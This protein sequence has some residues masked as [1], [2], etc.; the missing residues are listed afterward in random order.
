MSDTIEGIVEHIIFNNPDNGYTVLELS[1]AD[2]D[3]IVAVGSFPYVGVGE[4]ILVSGNMVDNPRYGEQFKADSFE[5]TV[6]SEPLLMERYLGSGAIKGVGKTLARRIVKAFGAETRHIIF[7]EPERLSEIKGIS[8]EKAR[9]IGREAAQK[10]DYQ[11]AMIFLT[12]YGIN[13]S[14]AFKLFNHYHNSIYDVLKT[15]PYRI[16][17]E[18]RG[19]GFLTADEIAMRSGLG[20]DS[21][22][23][24]RSGILY[25]LNQDI[26]NGNT[27][28]L[29][30]RLYENTAHMLGIE[31]REEDFDVLIQN[32]AFDR[33]IRVFSDKVFLRSIYQ[34]ENESASLL[35]DLNRIDPSSKKDYSEEIRS[36]LEEEGKSPDTMQIRAI[37]AAFNNGVS[38]L[39][40]GPGTG[41]T[42]TIEGM[43][44]FFSDKGKKVALTAPTGRAAKRMEETSGHDAFTIHRLLE[45]RGGGEDEE[46]SF[47][48]NRD[49]PLE[50]DVII[51][52]EMSMVDIRLFHSLLMAVPQGSRL[53]LAGDADQLPSVGPGN[54][55]KDIINSGAFSVVKLEKIFRQAEESN[56]VINAHKIISGVHMEIDNKSPDFCFLE[57]DNA[58]SAMSAVWQLVSSILPRHFG[59]SSSD[60]QVMSPTKKGYLGARAI[61][62]NLQLALNPHEAGKSE[63]HGKDGRILRTGDKVMQIKNNYDAEWLVRGLHG[64]AIESGKGVYNGDM[65]SIK[66]ISEETQE[67]V[68]EYDEKREVTYGFSELD[69]LELAYCITIHKSQ[70]SEYEA[71]VIPLLAVPRIMINRNLLYTAVTRARKSVVIVGER[72]I[73]DEMIDQSDTSERLTG[74]KD[75][76]IERKRL[77]QE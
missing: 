19:V 11:D 62:E 25:A 46:I 50:Y 51:V 47:D 24:I 56:I 49:N 3:E 48:R 67:L 41:K 68:V 40:G 20:A 5:I 54:V 64:I 12:Q 38:V 26:I 1:T 73:F 58:D 75:R 35:L 61:N 23:R 21:E 6:P 43:I 15:N 45:A 33:K 52:D 66:E 77:S 71:V 27:Y 14:L 9:D 65:G 2:E 30:D 69:Q 36:I 63:Y 44:R 72:K 17:E 18:V 55:L 74:L 32:L 42:T 10:R 60:I 37:N 31:I 8:D 70:G 39:T 22:F 57:R 4:N 29:K 13:G 34:L 28:T 59:C 16:A 76:I 53:I 7:D